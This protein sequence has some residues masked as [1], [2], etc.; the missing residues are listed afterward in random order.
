MSFA[1]VKFLEDNSVEVVAG[2][3]ITNDYCFWPPYRAARF[4]SAVKKSEIPDNTWQR[5]EIRVIGV[6]G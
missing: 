5:Y 4:T 6:Y 2:N 3:W 1:V